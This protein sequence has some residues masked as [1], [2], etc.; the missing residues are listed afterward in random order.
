M[1]VESQA[2]QFAEIA[3][4]REHMKH[5]SRELRIAER[6]HTSRD[7]RNAMAYLRD[8]NAK[9]PLEVWGPGSESGMAAP[10]ERQKWRL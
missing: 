5:E 6:E 9:P 7:A 1:Q 4:L 2:S 10:K 3:G 8:E